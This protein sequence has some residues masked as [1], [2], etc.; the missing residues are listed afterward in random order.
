MH[1]LPNLCYEGN[2]DLIPEL[3]KDVKDEKTIRQHFL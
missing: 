2:V 1:L 3:G